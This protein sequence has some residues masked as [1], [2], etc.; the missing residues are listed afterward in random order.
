MTTSSRV[1]RRR[2]L[3]VVLGVL[4]VLAVAAWGVTRSPFLDVDRVEIRGESR[5]G[6][7]D[8]AVASG[9]DRGDPMVWLDTGDAAARVESLPLVDTARVEREWPGTVRITVTERTPVGWVDA[10][11]GQAFVVDATG[12]A[13]TE[14]APPAGLPQIL[15]ATP[16]AAVGATITPTAGA[17]LAGHLL[18]E[19]RAVVRSIALKDGRATLVVTSGQEVRL[20]R[21]VGIVDKMRAAL[22]VLARPE[23]VGRTYVDVS[24]PS[25]PVAG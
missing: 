22:A 23:V 5:V 2:R 3:A 10:G 11:N 17:R 7:I 16:P 14:E 24:A 6:V 1:Y 9:I 18:P 8:V 4:L 20:G 13:L 25:T 19:A 12:R 21:P 15:G